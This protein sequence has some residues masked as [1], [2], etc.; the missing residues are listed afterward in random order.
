M[1]EQILILLLKLIL[2]FFLL[3]PTLK[4]KLILLHPAKLESQTVLLKLFFELQLYPNFTQQS[5]PISIKSLLSAFPHITFSILQVS[6]W[7]PLSIVLSASHLVFTTVALILLFLFLLLRFRLFPLQIFLGAQ[8]ADILAFEVVSTLTLQELKAVKELP[9]SIKQVVKLK[10]GFQREVCFT[11]EQTWV[12]GCYNGNFT[13]QQLAYK[14]VEL[15]LGL[16]ILD[17]PFISTTFIPLEEVQ[18]PLPVFMKGLMR[19]LAKMGL[20]NPYF[21]Y[22]FYPTNSIYEKQYEKILNSS[23]TLRGNSEFYLKSMGY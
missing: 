11:I 17:L 13:A 9:I 10:Q 19:V 15:V 14:L 21:D 16:M 7:L 23:Q 22:H 8:K 2:Y 5:T 6:F 20:R 3:Q 4:R 18:E 12:V 1:R